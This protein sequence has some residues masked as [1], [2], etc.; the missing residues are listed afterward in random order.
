MIK[1]RIG[2]S[3]SGRA[4]NTGGW[5]TARAQILQR[6]LRGVLAGLSWPGLGTVINRHSGGAWGVG[7]AIHLSV[8]ESNL[9]HLIAVNPTPTN[10]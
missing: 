8:Q 2:V 4:I 9:F 7:P 6:L 1:T 3:L 10:L 5:L